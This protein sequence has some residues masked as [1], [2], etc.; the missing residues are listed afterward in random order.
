MGSSADV[1]LPEKSLGII[2][3]VIRNFFELID[4]RAELDPSSSYK[5]HVQFLEI[6]GEEIKDLL[7]DTKTSKVNIRETVDGEVYVSGAKEELV[8][9]FEQMMKTLEN[10]TK[11]RVT[12]ATKMN[13]TSSRSHGEKFLAI[14]SFKSMGLC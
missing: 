1:A 13:A 7:D 8:N 4:R 3:R 14:I 6:Y 2:P 9:S 11:H 10:G 5:I 12:A